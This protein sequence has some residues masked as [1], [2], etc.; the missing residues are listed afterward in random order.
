MAVDRGKPQKKKGIHFENDSDLRG[1][2]PQARQYEAWKVTRR[3]GEG[4]LGVSVG[5]GGQKIFIY[6]FF[7]EGQKRQIKIGQY[8]KE[9]SLSQ[10]EEQAKK[11]TAQLQQGIN[12]KDEKEKAINAA[13]QA[14]REAAQKGSVEDLFNA[15]AES[16]QRDGKR[17]FAAVLAALN[18]ETRERIP[19]ATKAK[20]VTADQIKQ[21]LADMI[22]RGAKTQ[23]NRVRSYL[24]AA[25]NYGLKH[26]NNPATMGRGVLFGLTDNP[27]R[28]IP[29]QDDA[30]KVGQGCLN[31]NE[32]KQLRATFGSTHKV[33]WLTVSLLDLIL[34]TG[35]QRPYELLTARWE[36][37]NLIESTLLIPAEF[38]KNKRDHLLPL[39]ASALHVLEHIRQNAPPSPWVFA[40]R[41]T[42]RHVLP[43]TLSKALDYYRKANPDFP[44]IIPRD[45]R[46]TCKTLMGELGISKELRDRLQNHALNDVSSKH[47]DRYD[48][49]AEKR[50]ALEAWEARLDQIECPRNV[51][52]L[53]AVNQSNL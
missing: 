6:R 2:K 42:E 33:G 17:T 38:S 21:V 41:N 45:L 13:K 51:V 48:Y 11:F 10:A 15:Y 25:F 40:Q 29:K 1:L 8:L 31:L 50:K 46:R 43:T 19:P 34:Y 44:Y 47:Y 30:E 36:N 14:D 53:R 27:V 37:I 23:S 24:M 28:N 5:V 35:G 12:P 4:R 26:D 3:R 18:K 39:T 7:W 32:L 20:D 49:L 9:F 16:M 52:A 22:K